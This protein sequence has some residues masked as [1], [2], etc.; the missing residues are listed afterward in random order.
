MNNSDKTGI[1]RRDFVRVLGFTAATVVLSNCAENPFENTDKDDY[2]QELAKQEIEQDL[3]LAKQLYTPEFL[4]EYLREQE[5]HNCISFGTNF[6]WEH[7]NWLCHSPQDENWEIETPDI[8]E[9]FKQ[10]QELGIDT[11]RIPFYIDQC[12]FTKEKGGPKV[13]LR[14]KYI[15]MLETARDLDMKII[16]AYGLKSPRWPEVHIGNDQIEDIDQLW[17][18]K[19]PNEKGTIKLNSALGRFITDYTED[20]FKKLKIYKDVIYALQPEN[21]PFNHF[22]SRGWSIDPKLVLAELKLAH[23]Y[24]SDKQLHMNIPYSKEQPLTLYEEVIQK[25]PKDSKLAVFFNNYIMMPGSTYYTDQEGRGI[26]DDLGDSNRSGYK[27]ELRDTVQ[28]MLD[29]GIQT[30]ISELQMER[31]GD[32]DPL[33]YFYLFS[34]NILRQIRLLQLKENP[35]K[36][37]LDIWGIERL[38]LE[39]T[40]PN[41]KNYTTPAKKAA[42]ESVIT[43]LNN[44]K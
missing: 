35:R 7:F 22:G 17:K 9:T 6:S 42:L 1:S 44:D 37:R 3:E 20:L 8:R 31:W 29:E 12:Y 19:I 26:G 32:K 33:E 28:K 40:F 38:L 36:V 4:L 18:G 15:E 25:L 30:G 21:E 23:R 14:D 34:Y 16:V 13:E 2:E 24:F 41:E 27:E 11:V 39:K 5:L 10:I 43:V